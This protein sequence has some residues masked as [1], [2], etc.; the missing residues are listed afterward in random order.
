MALAS[1]A[2]ETCMN[3]LGTCESSGID[4]SAKLSFMF[5]ARGPHGTIGRVAA[6]KP[7]Q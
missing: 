7:S 2:L 4:G 6:L 3:V 1:G 5:E